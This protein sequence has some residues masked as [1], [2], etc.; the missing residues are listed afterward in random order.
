MAFDAGIG[1][2]TLDIQNLFPATATAAAPSVTTYIGLNVFSYQ[3]RRF[4]SA[5][6]SLESCQKEFLFPT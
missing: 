1:S 2:S 3:F 5:Q 4:A 6:G